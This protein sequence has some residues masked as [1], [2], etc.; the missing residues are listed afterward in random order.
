[1]LILTNLVFFLPKV[2]FSKKK[3]HKSLTRCQSICKLKDIYKYV[4]PLFQIISSFKFYKC[5]CIYIYSL[6]TRKE[7]RF[8]QQHG[9]QNTTLTSCFYKNIYR[10]VIYVY[11]YESIFQDKSINIIFTFSNLTT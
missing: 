10:K 5:V 9:L 2:P 11:F 6:R 4:L 1:M 3:L 8:G 7:S